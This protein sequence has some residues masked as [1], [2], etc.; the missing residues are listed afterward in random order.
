M[1]KTIKVSDVPLWLDGA[2]YGRTR[3]VVY[4]GEFTLQQKMFGHYVYSPN[5]DCVIE[6]T[7][8]RVR[9]IHKTRAVRN[10]LKQLDCYRQMVYDNSENIFAKKYWGK[11]DLVD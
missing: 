1:V 6:P 5:M 7:G 9:V 3:D 4:A 10:M 8:I 2:F 11:I